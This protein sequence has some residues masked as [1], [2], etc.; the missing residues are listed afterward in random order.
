MYPIGTKLHLAKDSIDLKLELHQ[1]ELITEP[2][3]YGEDEFLFTW[4]TTDGL[5]YLTTSD[6]LDG[7]LYDGATLTQPN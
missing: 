7:M 2:G 1:V 6:E 5:T 3:S 4:K